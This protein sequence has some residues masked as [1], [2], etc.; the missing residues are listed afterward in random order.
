M[1]PIPNLKSGTQ[2]AQSLY[3]HQICLSVI[4]FGNQSTYTM[5]G[6]DRARNSVKRRLGKLVSEL[7]LP[8]D[9]E[10]SCLDPAVKGCQELSEVQDMS[11][12]V[13]TKLCADWLFLEICPDSHYGTIAISENSPLLLF[14]LVLILLLYEYG[15]VVAYARYGRKPSILDS[16]IGIV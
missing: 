7:N 5:N 1:P 16:G 13:L 4:D 3:P 2:S 6:H 11:V 8:T 12:G 9:A 10:A 15:S 14:I